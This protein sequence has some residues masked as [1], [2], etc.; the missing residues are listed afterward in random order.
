VRRRIS[1]LD[2]APG[3][4]GALTL[5]GAFLL[6]PPEAAPTWTMDRR[7]NE[8]VIAKYVGDSIAEGESPPKVLAAARDLPAEFVVAE[9]GP[10]QPGRNSRSCPQR[11]RDDRD[12]TSLLVSISMGSAA[13]A[14]QHGDTTWRRTRGIGFYRVSPEGRYGVGKDQMLR[15]GCG[16]RT[17]MDIAGK[18]VALGALSTLNSR[19]DR[20]RRIAKEIKAMIHVEPDAVDLF[21][22]KL[23]IVVGDTNAVD[24]DAKAPRRFT[25]ELFE[26]V[27]AVLGS[28]AMPE[29]LS[30]TLRRS[31][32]VWITNM[33][34]NSM[35][36]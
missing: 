10:T 24:P 6:L 11:L 7:P 2:A 18:P 36:K 8:I 5:V 9:I 34:Y 32:S 30:V 22:Q 1:P 23:R 28:A 16:G 20:A 19:D 15:V 13:G 14:V 12:G 33:F 29:T 35:E 17:E 26:R 3:A 31:G 25:G 21:P 27:R 4:V